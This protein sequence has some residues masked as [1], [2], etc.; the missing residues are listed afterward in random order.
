MKITPSSSYTH[1]SSQDAVA[2]LDSSYEIAGSV[3][4]LPSER[5][6]NFKVTT[7]GKHQFVLKIASPFEKE[8]LVGFQDEV[9]NFLIQGK[10]PFSIP[11]PV[12]DKNGNNIVRFKNQSGQERLIRLVS[13]IEGERLSEVAHKDGK[14]I[15]SLGKSVASLHQ[16]LTTFD[17]EIPERDGFAW[18]LTNASKVISANLDYID[19]VDQ[20][21][22]L[23]KICE[24]LETDIQPI[25]QELPSSLLHNDANDHN[26]LVGPPSAEGRNV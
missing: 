12:P 17:E 6:Q 2:I 23:E 22:L 5:D 16:T 18:D 8:R 21:H 20:K 24:N 11:T 4:F 19:N 9:L 7:E 1:L 10:F 15:R 13:Y 26:I 14:L 25:L 3:D